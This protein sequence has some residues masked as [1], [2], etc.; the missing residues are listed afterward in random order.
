MQT[1]LPSTLLAHLQVAA[2]ENCAPVQ[3]CVDDGQVPREKHLPV[4]QTWFAIQTVPQLPQLATSVCRSAQTPSQVVVPLGQSATQRPLRHEP[5]LHAVPLGLFFL[6]LP[7][8]RF[9]HGGHDFFFLFVAPVV[10]LQS[11]P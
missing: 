1:V 9:L 3:I 4:W 10:L 8:L 5:P 11:V 6:H 2:Q 7:C